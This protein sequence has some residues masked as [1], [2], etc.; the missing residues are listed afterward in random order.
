[1]TNWGGSNPDPSMITEF[2]K[3]STAELRAGRACVKAVPVDWA[4]GSGD[5]D[6][7]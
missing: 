1:M 2:E 5:L 3:C 7:W 6:K 4:R